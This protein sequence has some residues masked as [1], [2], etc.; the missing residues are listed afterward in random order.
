MNVKF[1]KGLKA[2]LPSTRDN[3]TLYF[4]TDEGALY[5]GNTLI[6]ANYT[7]AIEAVNA[8]IKAI[9]DHGYV[10]STEVATAIGTAL[11]NYYT[12]EQVDA[13]IGTLKIGDVSYSSVVDYVIAKTTGIATDAVVANK[14]DKVV[15]SH[16]GNFAALGEDG[17]LIDSGKDYTVLQGEWNTDILNKIEQLNST[18]DNG[19]NDLV[20][21]T[22][23][24]SV[25]LLSSVTVDDSKLD[26]A[27]ADAEANAKSYADDAIAT[28]DAD[29]IKPWVA[30][31][32][33][34]LEFELVN[35]EIQ[36]KNE[37]G[38]VLASLDATEFIADGML[39]S[40]VADQT[41]NTLTFTWN[42]DAGVQETTVELSS[43]ADIY[44]GKTDNN[45]ISIHVSNTNEISAT[46][47]TTLD[48]RIID[49]ET[50]YN[51]GNHAEQGYLKAADISGKEDK[52]N[53]KALA[54][55][56]TIDS[57]DLVNDKVITKAKL[58]QD[59]QDILNSS[60]ILDTNVTFASV[61][62]EATMVA[63]AF[64]ADGTT[65]GAFDIQREYVSNGKNVIQ[66]LQFPEAKTDG[67]TEIVATQSYVD[68]AADNAVTAVQGATTNTV[69]DC[70]DAINA[71]NSQTGE[72]I[73]T[74]ENIVAQL[75]WGSF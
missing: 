64:T 72:V 6:G 25:G 32:F 34:N 30:T 42:T 9:N 59:V 5:L 22:V 37:S 57:A 63:S 40:V 66:I 67:E 58:E 19:E 24:Q 14:A 1:L 69:K 75:T 60:A 49:G 56:D 29:T 70:V 10:N 7:S 53:L 11:E 33:E 35:K 38:D 43:I 23:A 8:A 71:M 47:S 4:V 36:L 74:V 17:N 48:A 46:I 54:Y 44:T 45:G 52:S 20:K 3:T 27:I 2:N 50:A 68:T 62:A 26:K 15:P 51:W 65:Y 12:K 73:G 55:K 13:K 61:T 28:Y 18:K 41:N 16:A 21:V 39:Q 31:Q